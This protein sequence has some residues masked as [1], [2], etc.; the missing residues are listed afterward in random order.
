VKAW[1]INQ[2][3]LRMAAGAFVLWAVLLILAVIDP[4]LASAP[5]EAA[6]TVL[7]AIV[8]FVFGKEGL[9]AIR[10]AKHDD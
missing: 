6:R 7:L 4:T 10:G 1:D 8:G 5:A 3:G 2:V 9:Q